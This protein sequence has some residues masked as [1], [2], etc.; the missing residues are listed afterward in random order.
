M[1]SCTHHQSEAAH[2]R[3]NHYGGEA[4][5]AAA[6]LLLLS[7]AVQALHWEPCT[8]HCH[9]PSRLW[10]KGSPPELDRKVARAC[11]PANQQRTPFY[12]ISMRKA[13]VAAFNE[14]SVYPMAQ[15]RRSVAH[16]YSS[17]NL[18]MCMA[19]CELNSRAQTHQQYIYDL[20]NEGM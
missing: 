10:Q 12:A 7:H 16:V 3:L 11:K 4:R 14:I 8:Q 15:L 5:S 20:E 2:V 17:Y 6:V 9:V 19:G 1:L 18:L 13:A